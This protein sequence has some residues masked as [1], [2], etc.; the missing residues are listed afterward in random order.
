VGERAAY[1]LDGALAR[2]NAHDR[3]PA[4]GRAATQR[5]LVG[6]AHHDDRGG[7]PSRRAGERLVLGLL[8]SSTIPGV[9][10]TLR[11]SIGR[12]LSSSSAAPAPAGFAL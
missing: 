7:E 10:T 12:L 4:L 9:T 5:R 3:R 2:R 11:P 1:P 8:A 6:P